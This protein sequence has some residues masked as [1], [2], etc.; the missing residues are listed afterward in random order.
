V[1]APVAAPAGLDLPTQ[2]AA[3]KALRA[4]ADRL[5]A[6]PDAGWQGLIVVALTEE[7]AIFRYVQAVTV[8]AAVME[9]SDQ[10]AAFTDKVIAALRDSPLVPGDL[11]YG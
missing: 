7:P 2:R 11:N 1:A 3:R 5:R 10:N 6:S 8:R 4:L 9:A